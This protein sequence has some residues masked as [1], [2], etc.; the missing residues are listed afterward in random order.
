MTDI[1]LNEKFI[2]TV[3]SNKEFLK[4]FVRKN[5]DI[6]PEIFRAY[7][8]YGKY[9]IE[10]VKFT[11]KDERAFCLLEDKDKYLPWAW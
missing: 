9:K 11:K 10:E 1:F 8:K 6:S 7:K 5:F 3:E 4:Y 2:G